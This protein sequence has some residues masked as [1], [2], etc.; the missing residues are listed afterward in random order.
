MYQKNFLAIIPARAA[1]KGIPN[2]NLQLI[3][4]KPMIQFT[5]E[6]AISSVGESNTII[7]SNDVNALDLAKKL[8]LT[9]PFIRPEELS[10]DIATTSSVITHTI[11]WHKK[12]YG[13]IPDNLILLQPTSPFRTGGDIDKSI[14]KFISSKKQTLVSACEP[15]HNPGDFLFKNKDGKYTRLDTVKGKENINRRQQYPETY[16]IDG[17][18]YISKTSQFIETGDMIGHDPELFLTSQ[19]HAIDIDT[20]FDLDLARSIYEYGMES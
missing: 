7:S 17:G 8:G 11:Q 1:S 15:I 18:I 16:F 2:K 19:S 13:F 20:P 5:I 4:D 12:Q 14:K 10:T 9:V 3:G 6:A